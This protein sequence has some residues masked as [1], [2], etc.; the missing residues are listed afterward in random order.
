[1]RPC[2]FKYGIKCRDGMSMCQE[3]TIAKIHVQELAEYCIE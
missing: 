3:I 2:R 1:M